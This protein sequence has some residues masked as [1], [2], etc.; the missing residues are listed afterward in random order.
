[1]GNETS[2]LDKQYPILA[3]EASPSHSQI[4]ESL[5]DNLPY[6]VH[7]EGYIRRQESLPSEADYTD[8]S[9]N[10]NISRRLQF[11]GGNNWLR[12]IPGSCGTPTSDKG[13]L[14]E[15][16]V[17]KIGG[18]TTQNSS[19]DEDQTSGARDLS[20]A[21]SLQDSACE[22]LESS[23][24]MTEEEK[25][26]IKNVLDRVKQVETL[27]AK[28]ISNIKMELQQ[29]EDEVSQRVVNSAQDIYSSLD[30][31]DF[32]DS[33]SEK[34]SDIDSTRPEIWQCNDCGRRTC[35]NCCIHIDHNEST[36]GVVICG[37]CQRKRKLIAS[38]GAWTRQAPIESHEPPIPIH[39][40]HSYGGYEI[41]FDANDTSSWGVSNV[42][43]LSIPKTSIWNPL[44][45]RDTLSQTQDVL[46]P[47]IKIE[48]P[49][50]SNFPDIIHD[51]ESIV[52]QNSRHSFRTFEVDETI[53]SSDSECPDT[54]RVK[55]LFLP[56]RIC[57]SPS[58]CYRDLTAPD[59]DFHSA[60][61]D[62]MMAVYYSDPWSYY[63][64]N[65]IDPDKV[66]EHF[67]R[68]K[69]DIFQ[70]D[71]PPFGPISE[72]AEEELAEIHQ[73][74]SNTSILTTTT[75]SDS[76][77]PKRP[78]NRI[79]SRHLSLDGLN[80]KKNVLHDN[81]SCLQLEELSESGHVLLQQVPKEI[82][83]SNQY[84][85]ISPIA[86]VFHI[87]PVI[88]Q[89]CGSLRRVKVNEPQEIF[90]DGAIQNPGIDFQ[91]YAIANWG[92]VSQL[93]DESVRIIAG[94]EDEDDESIE[95][96]EV[97][98][99]EL[100]MIPEEE[101]KSSLPQMRKCQNFENINKMIVTGSPL[102]PVV[103]E[104]SND[105]RETGSESP[106][107]FDEQTL[108]RWGR[109]TYLQNLTT[110]AEDQVL[111]KQE[112]QLWANL[113]A[114]SED[115]VVESA[116]GISAQLQELSHLDE[117][118]VELADSQLSPT[119]LNKAVKEQT[120][121]ERSLNEK[122]FATLV[123]E[124]IKS[125]ESEM[126]FCQQQVGEK[127][128][129]QGR[130]LLPQ[131]PKRA[132]E[133]ELI[134]KRP[135]TEIEM[136]LNALE[137]EEVVQK[138]ELGE[139]SE[140]DTQTISLSTHISE[141]DMNTEIGYRLQGEETEQPIVSQQSREAGRKADLSIQ[142]EDSSP[143]HR[144]KAITTP[145]SP[146]PTTHHPSEEGRNVL[147][148]PNALV[149]HSS[150]VTQPFLE[151]NLHV[152]SVTVAASEEEPLSLFTE[153]VRSQ[154]VDHL[155]LLDLDSPVSDTRSN[156]S[157]VIGSCLWSI[158]CRS[159]SRQFNRAIKTLTER[160]EDSASFLES[161]DTLLALL[162]S[163]SDP[164]KASGPRVV[165]KTRRVR[166][167]QICDT[168]IEEHEGKCSI[169]PSADREQRIEF[170]TAKHLFST[171][172]YENPL[173]LDMTTAMR[174]KRSQSYVAPSEFDSSYARQQ[175][176]HAH[177]RLHETPSHGNV[178]TYAKHRS[179][180]I[181]S[182]PRNLTSFQ[183]YGESEGN[184]PS[185]WSP[186]PDK[187]ISAGLSPKHA[188]IK[189]SQFNSRA[190]SSRDNIALS[191]SGFTLRQSVNNGSYQRVN[192]YSA[193]MDDYGSGDSGGSNSSYR[194]RL[195]EQRKHG[196]TPGSARLSGEVST[197]RAGYENA[198]T[199]RSSTLPYKRRGSWHVDRESNFSTLDLNNSRNHW[200]RSRWRS[201]SP[202]RLVVDTT[203]EG[204][205]PTLAPETRC[206]RSQSLH[207]K[208]LRELAKSTE[209]L[210]I[211]FLDNYKGIETSFGTLRAKLD[212]A[213]SQGSEFRRQA[214]ADRLFG[215]DPTAEQL[216]RQCERE[217]RRLLKSLMSDSWEKGMDRHPKPPQ[218]YFNQTPGVVLPV[219]EATLLTAPRTT[220]PLTNPNLE[221]LLRNPTLMQLLANHAAQTQQ[222]PDQSSLAD[223]VTLAAVAGAAAATAMANFTN[224]PNEQSS[225]SNL[226]VQTTS[227][228]D[229]YDWN[230]PETLMAAYTAL[231]EASGGEKAF[232][233][234]LSPELAATLV[235]YREQLSEKLSTNEGG[236]VPVASNTTISA[237]T[238]TGVMTSVNNNSV[239]S[240]IG[241]NHSG[242]MLE[243][244]SRHIRMDKD[245][246]VPNGR[247]KL[248]TTSA[249]DVSG[250]IRNNADLT[251]TKIQRRSYEF[252]TKRLLLMR[253]SKGRA[254]GGNGFGLKIVGGRQ[255]PDG[256]LG[257]YVEQIHSGETLGYLH[258]EISEGDEVLE[259]NGVV[260]TGKGA[261]EVQSIVDSPADEVELLVRINPSENIRY[262][263]EF[264]YHTCSRR[265]P[266]TTETHRYQ[267]PKLCPS[268]NPNPHLHESLH[269][270]NGSI[271]S[272]VHQHTCQQPQQGSRGPP[273]HTCEVHP[274]GPA[275]IHKQQQQH[276]CRSADWPS[277]D[278]RSPYSQRGVMDQQT[279]NSPQSERNA[280][281]TL[282]S[283]STRSESFSHRHQRHVVPTVNIADFDVAGDRS[284]PDTISHNSGG[285]TNE[286]GNFVNDEENSEPYGEIE[287]ILTFDDYDQSLTVH[288]A[289]ARGLRPMDL[290]GL[291]DPFVKLRLHP[292]PTEDMD[293][294]RQI[295][296][297]T[298]TLEPEWQQTVVFIN[299]LKRTL[300]KRVLEVTVWDFDRL[301]M[302]DFMGQAII[303]LGSKETLDGQPHWYRLH[304]LQDIVIPG[305]RQPGTR[306]V[307]PPITQNDQ[308]KTIK[309][310]KEV[311]TP[312]TKGIQ[313]GRSH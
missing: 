185:M 103:E 125:P 66:N 188:R 106:A 84:E 52:S 135:I 259:W 242:V 294:N 56:N 246:V 169:L 178:P 1:M 249:N 49:T 38:S 245:V 100:G 257:S 200:S 227:T 247:L 138:F 235:H 263:Q 140:A 141:A 102:Y 23:Q 161:T 35:P 132:D 205:P 162:Q 126:R 170:I 157:G 105:E 12:T 210:S 244:V 39:R 256:R 70:I 167:T 134:I 176:L 81:F 118:A 177:P 111:V 163:E 217:H 89:G 120:Q 237:A 133:E 59:H 34:L 175:Q 248:S 214:S 7:H 79:L 45:F 74:F 154:S 28:R 296:Y 180:T 123:G 77:L 207:S 293:L 308:I 18:G 182:M 88:E 153:P 86:S 13:S 284:A 310:V 67:E 128:E 218:Q 137:H 108:H 274:M 4:V 69:E 181:S 95:F 72:E 221:K 142:S 304:A 288:V 283:P 191:S 99:E 240:D 129:P 252:P 145:S 290:N 208:H 110:Y 114:P 156:R 116:K 190:L 97:E 37:L 22:I 94:C 239:F 51:E 287:L 258:G 203:N 285:Q 98:S 58:N 90:V 232:L 266:C 186:P 276:V 243:D 44:N 73:S 121:E 268:H 151:Q 139:I 24:Q 174:T 279:P 91:A 238:S 109:R 122:Q 113:F 306:A 226:P 172:T 297:I 55:S 255:R 305:Y 300:K 225:Y 20:S 199:N 215:R 136:T 53:Q 96:S 312:Q 251:P 17:K 30:G 63:D 149:H 71:D 11:P 78:V 82:L 187:S 147:L 64:P 202:E 286:D 278:T 75:T 213:S 277:K 289:R 43:R 165:A 264:P 295:K 32:C 159:K 50:A 229:E 301:K 265:S 47:T 222:T 68:G 273:M 307:A 80:K 253:S 10:S 61:T 224:P 29:E 212:A 219:Q 194:K 171:L 8:S 92:Q 164:S 223:Q 144:F 143:L 313:K 160:T 127:V 230:D 204:G 150:R 311:K 15:A 254:S 197:I 101:E 25:A 33:F 292:D 40:A 189:S 216:R 231:A 16:L 270:G 228:R 46:L 298:N 260:L 62:E 173:F 198:M 241:N 179:F 9:E 31:C 275:C 76:Q 48:S 168:T 19:I 27:E 41:P 42:K 148:L 104:G 206:F 57:S 6:S 269:G 146:S 85:D 192:R 291:A 282:A 271:N 36:D 196:K 299:C 152:D 65:T 184:F 119:I 267:P 117:D 193:S 21:V 124:K 5:P 211:G 130:R 220:N 281:E 87:D 233:E 166:L 280:N 158:L 250:R 272:C 54:E 236:K 183:R 309:L 107:L 234:Q 155:P 302:N 261:A 115:I 14:L 112:E 131:L 209:Q 195:L 303:H 2:F 262:P 26:K 3:F 83:I 93:D 201:F 60:F